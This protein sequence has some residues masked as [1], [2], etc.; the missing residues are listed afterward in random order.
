MAN[1]ETTFRVRMPADFRAQA[2]AAAQAKGIELSGYVRAAMIHLIE[3][4]EIPFEC[5]DVL[6]NG[7]PAG[8]PR[9]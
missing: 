2:H 9:K 5:K 1:T 4:N 3:G 7:Y 8:R 6:K